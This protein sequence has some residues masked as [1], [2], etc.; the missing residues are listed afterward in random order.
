MKKSILICLIGLFMLAGTQYT[1]AQTK[2]ETIA[3]IK[4]KLEKYGEPKIHQSRIL[5]WPGLNAPSFFSKKLVPSN[6]SFIESRVTGEP[7]GRFYSY[8]VIFDYKY[9]YI[10]GETLMI[11]NDYAIIF[12]SVEW[13]IPIRGTSFD[14]RD[15]NNKLPKI[16]ITTIEKTTNPKGNDK[17]IEKDEEDSRYVSSVPFYIREGEENLIERLN[18]AFQHLETFLPEE[19]KEAF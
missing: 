6:F 3:W 9:L 13:K 17:V 15:L 14:G 11:E 19:K 4:E 1:Q 8:D 18:K 16:L 5:T 7:K 12:G 2:E 10:F